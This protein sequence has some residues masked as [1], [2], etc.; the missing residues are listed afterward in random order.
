MNDLSPQRP[1][2][3]LLVDGDNLSHGHAGALILQ[4]ARHGALTIKRVYGN[5][6]KLP[7]WND[8]PGFK[9]IHAGTGK[10]ASDLLLAV[11]ATAV[12]LTGQAD[13]LVIASSDRDF[14]H[15]ALHLTERG[16]TVI[17]LGE[18][19]A[20]DHFRKS[21]TRFHE[22]PSAAAPTPL[23]LPPPAPIDPL[24]APAKALI[25][26]EPA[27]ITLTQLS[28]RMAT[29]NAIQIRQTPH[30]TWRAFLLSWP[31][32]FA[33]DDNGTATRVILKP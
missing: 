1:R 10:N 6:A 22:L 28:N 2:V 31:E 27:G 19:K 30:K 21:C 5:M 24:I 9:C 26:A 14:S 16:L 18:A 13:V 11:E 7:G 23:P 3:A 15:L 29:A 20:P 17:G 4:A 32:H 33:L 8:A 12:M 25:A